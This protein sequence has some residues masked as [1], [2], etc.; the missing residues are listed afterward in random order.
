MQQV[1]AKALSAEASAQNHRT[2][3]NVPLHRT[4]SPYVHWVTDHLPTSKFHGGVET[5]F[6]A[7]SRRR[8]RPRLARLLQSCFHDRR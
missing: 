2:Y 1:A 8:N 5:D 7:R 6:G 4:K 3:K